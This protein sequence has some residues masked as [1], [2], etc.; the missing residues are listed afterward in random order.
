MKWYAVGAALVL[1]LALW[2]CG[3]HDVVVELDST[4]SDADKSE[5]QRAGGAWDGVA[6]DKVRF[7]DHGDW[8][9]IRGEVPYGFNGYTEPAR[10]LIRIN[11]DVPTTEIYIVAAH[12]LGHT[13]KLEHTCVSP[14]PRMSAAAPGAPPC[15]DTSHGVMDPINA[16][17]ALAPEDLEECRRVGSCN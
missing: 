1:S 10:H 6:G 11:P 4:L 5:V 2:G 12:E 3:S 13:L 17:P 7:S 14:D 16:Q 8:L 15:G 9:L